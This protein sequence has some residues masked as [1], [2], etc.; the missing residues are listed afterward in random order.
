M[1]TDERRALIDSISRD[2]LRVRSIA[3]DALAYAT[4]TEAYR[5]AFQDIIDALDDDGRA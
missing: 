5:R 3:L 1:N 4:S 2:I